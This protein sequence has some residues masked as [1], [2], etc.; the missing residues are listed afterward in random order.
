LK[1]LKK[2][3]T[4]TSICSIYSSSASTIRNTKL[5]TNTCKNLMYRN[6]H[7]PIT[8]FSSDSRHQNWRFSIPETKTW[9]C[10]WF[11][12]SSIYLPF[13][14]PFNKDGNSFIFQTPS[15][16]SKRPLSKRTLLKFCMLLLPLPFY[17][18]V[19]LIDFI[20]DY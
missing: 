1:G 20:C 18:H 12:A 3:E 19:P 17:L 16:S 14:N 7:N 6:G 2:H 10:I 13:S 15:F 9:F 8:H 11:W 4:N 5:Q